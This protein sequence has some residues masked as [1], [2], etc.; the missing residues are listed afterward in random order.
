MCG[1]AGIFGDAVGDDRLRAA[2]D[3]VATRGP[4]DSG[5]HQLTGPMPGGLAHR[6][7]S[8]IDLTHHGAQPMVDDEAGIALAYNGEIYNSPALRD[9]LRSLGMSFRSHSDTEVL[10]RGWQAWGDQVLERIEGIFSFA[11]VD[12]RRGRVLL[13]RDRLGVKPLYWGLDG[14]T[15][16]AGST[17]RA[18]LALRPTLGDQLD[19]LAL[20]QYLTL[21]WIPHPRTPWARIHKL[22]PGRALAFEAGAVSLSTYWS[23][24]PV[25]ANRGAADL[26]P[27]GL[28]G[29]VCA[30]TRAQLLSDVPVGMLFS[31]GLDS[32]L[33]LSCMV[34]DRESGAPPVAA[35]TAGYDAASQQLEMVPDDL[36]FARQVARSDGRI[37]LT[38]V[39]ISG[40]PRRALDALT[41]LAPHFDDPV[42]DPAAL[43]LW[44]LCRASPTKVLL[45][46]VGGEE[47]FAGYP[48]HLALAT[49]RRAATAPFAARR[50]LAAGASQLRGGR[51]GPGYGLRRNVQKLARAIGDCPTPHY[52]RMMSQLTTA[53]LDTLMPGAA[54]AAHE[55]LDA[56]STPLADTSL[57]DALRFDR[58]QFLPNLNLAYVDRASMASG[59]EVRV[60]LLDERLVET[61]FATDP[62]HLV[63]HGVGKV[64]LRR[65]ARGLVPDPVIDRA[66]TGFGGPV[67]QWMRGPDSADIQERI[68]ASADAGLVTR[69]G[70]RRIYAD[71]S[72]GRVDSALAAWALACLGAWHDAHGRADK[73]ST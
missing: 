73:G 35:L 26:D 17:P 46:G 27:P 48:R 55:A 70:A 14:D 72:T 53:E 40:E 66:K 1:W 18:L 68:E 28:A 56:L 69:A 49:A 31:G 29:G 37:D 23:A 41:A 64:P 15:L 25:M 6:R 2:G 38:E 24:P 36:E 9:E 7:L 5:V 12:E 39:E 3:A 33:L 52:W 20:G 13:A 63:D 11:L 44:H 51:S 61:V 62:T 30:A 42:A 57:G 21:L 47:L 34:R 19:H 58:S 45:S 4:D 10:L 59:I 22:E 50:A 8:I 65:A 71:A 32:T 43:T 54:I 67:R 60:P 16:V